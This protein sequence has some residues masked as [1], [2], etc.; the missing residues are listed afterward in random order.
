MI[1]RSDGRLTVPMKQGQGEV[2]GDPWLRAHAKVGLMA[3]PRILTWY[4]NH[5]SAYWV[6][7][8]VAQQLQQIGVVINQNDKSYVSDAVRRL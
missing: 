3:R 2:G 4:V 8:N 5:A 1:I 6:G 7:M